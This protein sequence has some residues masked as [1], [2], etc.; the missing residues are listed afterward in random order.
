LMEGLGKEGLCRRKG[1]RPAKGPTR[2]KK[3]K[4]VLFLRNCV[5]K[6]GV[7]KKKKEPPIKKDRS[8][9]EEGGKQLQVEKVK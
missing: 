8:L 5:A 2:G 7:N 1:D 3:G 9:G 4:Q 6:G